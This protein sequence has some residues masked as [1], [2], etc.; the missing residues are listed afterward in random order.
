MAAQHPALPEHW[1]QLLSSLLLSYL[2]VSG[3]NVGALSRG[4]CGPPLVCCAAVWVCVFFVVVVLFALE[5]IRW[6]PGRWISKSAV[7]QN[8]RL[9][10]KRLNSTKST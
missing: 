2:S 8:K 5:L 4:L 6:K 1:W 7:S 9:K 3:S 10:R